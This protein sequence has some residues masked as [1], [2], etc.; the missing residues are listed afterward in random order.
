[1]LA[2]LLIIG[3]GTSATSFAQQ[4]NTQQVTRT[5]INDCIRLARERGWTDSDLNTGGAQ[6]NPARDFVIRCLQGTQR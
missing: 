6:S 4:E 1:M 3:V 5:S 2:A